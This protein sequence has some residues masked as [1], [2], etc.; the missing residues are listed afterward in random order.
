ML[1]LYKHLEKK[2]PELHP[3]EWGGGGG[4]GGIVWM[5]PSAFGTSLIHGS[6]PLYIRAFVTS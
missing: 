5:Q 4:G 1:V 3:W 2:L 6:T